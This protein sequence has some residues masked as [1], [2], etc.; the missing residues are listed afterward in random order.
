MSQAPSLFSMNTVFLEG[1]G[2]YCELLGHD[3]GLYKNP[4]DRYGQLSGELFRAGRLVVDPGIHAKGWSKEKALKYL[5][6]HSDF[7]ETFIKQELDRYVTDPGQAVSYKI[8]Q[9][10][11]KN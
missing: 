2:M 7:D 9:L 6:D 4:M 3:L 5:L 11:V 8:G 10:E 1:W